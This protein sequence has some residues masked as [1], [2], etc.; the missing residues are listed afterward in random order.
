MLLSFLGS[1]QSWNYPNFYPNN[2]YDSWTLVAP[3]GQKI[4]MKFTS[5]KIECDC[6]ECN[7]SGMVYLEKKYIFWKSNDLPNYKVSKNLQLKF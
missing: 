3:I 7:N 2:K 4:E 6:T 5:L 1:I